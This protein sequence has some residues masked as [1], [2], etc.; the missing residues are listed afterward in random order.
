MDSLHNSSYIS[1]VFLPS[2]NTDVS[3]IHELLYSESYCTVYTFNVYITSI[4]A[5]YEQ[6][7][8]LQLLTGELLI[9]V[10]H[11]T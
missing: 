3:E 11:V 8:I 2:T 6:E 1:C 10:L 7:N 9:G 5:F 4:I